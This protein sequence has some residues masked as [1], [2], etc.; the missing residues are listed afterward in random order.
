MNGWTY[1]AVIAFIPSNPMDQS[2]W[3]FQMA[4]ISTCIAM[5][6]HRHPGYGR[7]PKADAGLTMT[8]MAKACW[9]A[10]DELCPAR[11]RFW[12][13]VRWARPR[14]PHVPPAPDK[15]RHSC[16]GHRFTTQQGIYQGRIDNYTGQWHRLSLGLH[17][18]GSEPGVSHDTDGTFFATFHR[19]AT[20]TPTCRRCIHQFKA[21]ANPIRRAI[22]SGIACRQ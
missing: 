7:S 16:V 12:S 18:R 4:H 5:H 3:I 14:S 22:M 11:K 1:G 17:V 6:C 19:G 13:A 10:I 2:C 20:N 21:L 15:T 8:D 9:E